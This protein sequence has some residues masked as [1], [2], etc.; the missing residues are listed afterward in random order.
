MFKVNLRLFGSKSATPDPVAETQKQIDEMLKKAQESAQKIIED[1]V[2]KA[3]DVLEKD[4]PTSGPVQQTDKDK[5]A[6]E[7]YMNELVPVYLFKDNN[8]YR[9]D[10]QITVN[11]ESIL[12]QRGKHIKIK[13]KFAEALDI[14]QV[15][16]AFA[17]DHMQGLIDSYK[18]KEPRLS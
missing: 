16:D 7:A 18:E 6:F 5:A 10:V 4:T 9:D 8:K 14:S 1:A 15:Q 2:K 12:L 13:R 11:G 3:Q 17:A